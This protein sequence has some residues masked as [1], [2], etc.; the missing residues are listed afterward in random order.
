MT[1]GEAADRW[2]PATLVCLLL[3]DRGEHSKVL[4]PAVCSGRAERKR[5]EVCLC[6]G[7]RA[8]DECNGEVGRGTPRDIKVSGVSQG[9]TWH[10]LTHLCAFPT[11]PKRSGHYR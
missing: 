4:A 1:P 9:L 8:E 11:A 10:T 7:R 2:D 5:L 6:P 3:G